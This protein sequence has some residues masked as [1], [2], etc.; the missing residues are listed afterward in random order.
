MIAL[1]KKKKKKKFTV[2]LKLQAQLRQN[3]SLNSMASFRTN[4]MFTNACSMFF[5][6]KFCN[7]LGKY[8][9]TDVY[10]LKRWFSVYGT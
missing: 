3:S 5:S 2:A 8:H 4:H 7:G 10:K 1:Q 9:V 6:F